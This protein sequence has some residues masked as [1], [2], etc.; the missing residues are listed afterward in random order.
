MNFD[1]CSYSRANSSS[2][3][4]TDC[5]WLAGAVRQGGRGAVDGEKTKAKMKKLTTDS[6]G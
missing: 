3:C 4:Q 6:P 2:V 5:E 1:P